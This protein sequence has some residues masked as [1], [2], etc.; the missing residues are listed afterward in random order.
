LSFIRPGSEKDTGAKQKAY[1]ATTLLTDHV[2][3]KGDEI[4]LEFDS[5][6]GGHTKRT[7]TD[8]LLAEILEDRLQERQSGVQLFD[9]DAGKVNDYIQKTAIDIGMP[10]ANNLKYTIKDFRTH[11]AT[12]LALQEMSSGDYSMDPPPTAEQIQ[13]KI[14]AVNKRRTVPPAIP[15]KKRKTKGKLET[16]TEFKERVGKAKERRSKWKQQEPLEGDG[17]RAEV[18]NQFELALNRTK[19][20]IAEV[21]AEQLQNTP[22]MAIKS[23]M[24]PHIFED[25]NNTYEDTA[26]RVTSQMVGD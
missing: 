19:K 12:S 9:T 18:L 13:K 15:D 26:R 16:N 3:V 22:A 11:G 8:K 24:S 20:P 2:T 10:G 1:G 6:K 14:D 5:K 4:T 7:I 17:L 23:Y 21:V 25:W